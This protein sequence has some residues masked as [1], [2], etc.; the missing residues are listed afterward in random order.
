M[1]EG[2]GCLPPASSLVTARLV[3]PPATRRNARVTS[4][5]FRAKVA[6]GR[7]MK[8]PLP[9]SR[10]LA[11][12]AALPL[13]GATPAEPYG[14]AAAIAFARGFRGEVYKA[15]TLHCWPDAKGVPFADC[16]HIIPMTANLWTPRQ[17]AADFQRR[18]AALSPAERKRGIVVLL[19]TERCATKSLRACTVT[20]SALEKRATPLAA[21]FAIYGLLLLPR[22]K[23]DPPGSLKIET[24]L[25]AWKNDAA[26]EYQFK[27]GPG[28]TLAFL[29]P[30]GTLIERSDAMALGLTESEFLE[31][32]GRT[33]KL[34]AKLE[35]VLA[36]LGS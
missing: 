36:R 15:N 7:P 30:D 24:G 21:E 12:L 5:R 4:T 29:R 33:P 19:K 9:L 27:Q 3:V 14:P 35:S 2:S 34:H 26:G 1:T 23:D 31:E 13:L 6:V 16:E 8:V 32:Q 17:I 18:M 25:D 28:A 20:T 10:A 11:L 22:D